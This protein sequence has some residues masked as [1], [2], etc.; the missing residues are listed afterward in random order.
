MQGNKTVVRALYAIRLKRPRRSLSHGEEERRTR[1]LPS[2]IH[3]RTLKFSCGAITSSFVH[4]QARLVNSSSGVPVSDLH[5]HSIVLLSLVL[6]HTT[7]AFIP[8]RRP[9]RYLLV[10]LQG[11]HRWTPLW[12][13][14]RTTRRT[15]TFPGKFINEKYEKQERRRRE[16]ENPN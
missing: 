3:Q 2:T 5:L 9:V 10:V 11:E 16:A 6:R 12:R 1:T 8:C 13:P 14:T 15:R 7:Q 4:Y